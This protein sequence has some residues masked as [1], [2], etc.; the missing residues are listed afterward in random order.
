MF[1]CL[2]GTLGLALG[3]QTWQFWDANLT[4]STEWKTKIEIDFCC[5][6]KTSRQNN[7]SI[8]QMY[9]FLRHVFAYSPF[10]TLIGSFIVVLVWTSINI[11]S[12][13]KFISYS[14]LIKNLKNDVDIEVI[15]RCASGQISE[16]DI[17]HNCDI[18]EEVF[19]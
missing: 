13:K 16:Y 1:P 8:C 6:A 18:C 11:A 12:L 19:H 4:S 10:L 2:I 3:G 15:S 7:A 14:T 5:S 9:Q 17:C